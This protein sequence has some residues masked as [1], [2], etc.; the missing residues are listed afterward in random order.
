MQQYTAHATPFARGY[1]GGGSLRGIYD[2]ANDFSLA[3]PFNLRKINLPLHEYKSGL[4]S[5]IFRA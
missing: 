3:L 1:A 4:L 2:S 5:Y